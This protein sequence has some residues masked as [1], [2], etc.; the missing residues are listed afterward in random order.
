MNT[1]RGVRDGKAD[2]DDTS[3]NTASGSTASGG[4]AHRPKRRKL[5]RVAK[6]SALAACFLAIGT[7]GVGTWKLRSSLP[8]ISGVHRTQ[9]VVDPIQVE[10]D[11]M[12]IPTIESKSRV[13]A[14]YGLGY[15]HG[16]DRFFQMDLLRRMTAGRLSEL[17]GKGAVG[18]DKRYRKHRFTR[19][20]ETIYESLAIEQKELVDAYARGVNEGLHRLEDE[21]FEYQVLQLLPEDWE[22][23]DSFLVMLTML[24][25]LQPMD[26]TPE[27][28]LTELHEKV[29]EE[30]FAYLVRAG[31]RWDAAIDGSEVTMPAIPS[32]EVWS[33][34]VG[35]EHQGVARESAADVLNSKGREEVVAT[36]GGEIRSPELF[37]G[38]WH[39]DLPLE[40]RVGSN[41]WAVSSK[42]GRSSADGVSADTAEGR[43]GRAILASDMHLGLNVPT[44]WYRAV[45]RTPTA[46]GKDRQLVGVTLPGTPVLIEG[47]NGSVAWGF[48]N[49]YGDY[50]DL[51]ELKMVSEREYATPSG[52][53]ELET[54]TETFVFSGG[55]EEADFEWSVWG[56]VVEKR[57]GRRFVHRWVGNDPNAFNLNIVQMESAETID[58]LAEIV[59]RVGMP[60]Q[61]VMMADIHG[62]IGWTISGRIPKR[63]GAPSLIA[64]DWSQEEQW[65]GYLESS[66]VPK[67]MRPES[68]RLWT[69]NN[70]IMGQ[71]YLQLVGDGRFD[72]GARARQIRDR[73]FEKDVFSEED[74]LKIQLDDEAR[75]MKVWQG[76]LRQVTEGSQGV[77]EEFKG[78]VAEETLRASVDSVAYRVVHEFRGQVLLRV[79]GIDVVRRGAGGGK[80]VGLAGRLG[81]ER[82]VSISYEDVVEELLE[83]RPEHWLPVEYESWDALLLDAAKST[84][85]ELTREQPLSQA[86][87][88][89]RNRAA[90]RHPLTRAV[91]ALGSFLDM[92]AVELPGDSH[93]PRVQSPSGGASQRLVV[94]PGLEGAGIYHQPGGASGHP[95]SSY[96]RAGFDDWANGV[97][98]SLLPSEPVHRM[99]IVPEGRR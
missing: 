50:G 21:P 72:P 88:G 34:R 31:S 60:N 10:R 1:N 46:D 79:F 75:M 96:Y 78:Y 20:A 92:P 93:L 77:S 52:P 76:W 63:R 65:V 40:F 23:K 71:E 5:R 47:S 22:P 84:E 97:A 12:G 30:V 98:S 42:V 2:L 43:P 53:K 80:K 13:D 55:S 90:I 14:A 3:G 35:N 45:M 24:C 81:M 41:N 54:F 61:N 7:T 39:E 91:P 94:S 74:L 85:V 66:E 89:K 18:T 37:W 59:H 87:W 15:V 17:V 67:V 29:P 51:I 70:R 19:M 57:D 11:A 64:A 25:D 62:D 86:T 69:A 6:T 48:T 32:E 36:H 95:L 83:Q 38:S 56:P 27:L 44:I 49:S 8:V 68:G 33:L 16:Q 99:Q 9:H 73:L 58:E 4:T 26:G 28:A 82:G